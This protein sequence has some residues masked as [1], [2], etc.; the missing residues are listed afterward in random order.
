MPNIIDSSKLLMGRMMSQPMMISSIIEHAKKHHGST[1]IVSRR[2]EGD[3]HRYTF[4]DCE[5]RAK[6]VAQALEKLGIEPGNR[7]GTLAWNGYRH[8]ELYYGISGSGLVC[9][10]INP[11]LFEEQIT[12]IINHAED[13]AIFFDITFL[14]IIQKIYGECPIVGHWVCMIDRDQ[15]PQDQPLE[16]LCYEDILETEN[17][18]YQWPIFDENAASALCYTSG[19]TGRPKGALYSHRSTILHSYASALPDALNISALDTI[20][21]VVP[22][23]HVNAWG[24]PYSAPMVGAKIV[25]PGSQLDGASLYEL[26]ETENVTMSAGVPTIWSALLQQVN[27]NRLKFSSFR[28]S[29]IGG[30]ACPPTMMRAFEDH[31]VKVIHAWGMTELSPVGTVAGLKKSDLKKSKEDQQLILQKQGR[32]IYGV[33]LKIVNEDG[34]TLENNGRDFGNLM[35]KGSWVVA[36]YFGSDPSPLIKGWFPTGDVS[37]IDPDGN[38]Q[39]T[40][41]RKDVI[42]SGGEWISSIEIENIA[43]AHPSVFACA[44]IA[45]PHPKWQERPI[46]L[47][48]KKPDATQDDISLKVSLLQFISEKIAKWSTPDD[49]LFIEK[50]P[51]TATGKV[52]KVRLREMLKDYKSLS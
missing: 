18:D 41:R 48:V 32:A 46:L 52:L 11:R 5:L 40:D 39:I 3:I 10:T 7:V 1:E 28:R 37:T 44:C 36:E 24:I 9:H 14:P 20:M 33:D 42:K 2:T 22:M 12:Y 30:S 23:F 45:V 13:K 31:G 34:A 38:M 6:K 29:I 49:V 15:M 21:P 4:I 25:F 51:M 17:G 16:L 47:V 26:M 27:D 8:L 43:S 35:A 50:M 19:T